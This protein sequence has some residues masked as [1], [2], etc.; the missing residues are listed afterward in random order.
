MYHCATFTAAAT[1]FK[2]ILGLPFTPTKIRFTVN[3]TDATPYH[4]A[5][6]ATSSSSQE[7]HTSYFD[8][9]PTEIV[10]D[11]T[12]CL[13]HYERQSGVLVKVL[14]FSFVSFGVGRFKIN[15]DTANSNIQIFAEVW[16]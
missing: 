2:T 9:A 12:K 8:V 13:T 3:K 5:G 11:S 6:E 15:V 16:G 1:G 14:S 4:S 10:S 7:A